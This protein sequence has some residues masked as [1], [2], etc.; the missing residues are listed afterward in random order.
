MKLKDITRVTQQNILD[1]NLNLAK[2]TYQ[3]KLAVSSCL[4]GYPSLNST[5]F[6]IKLK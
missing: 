2:G 1:V 3:C 4:P 5:G 6:E